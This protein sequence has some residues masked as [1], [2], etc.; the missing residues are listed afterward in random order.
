MGSWVGDLL[1]DDSATMRP[2]QDE[3]GNRCVQDQMDGVAKTSG[4]AEKQKKLSF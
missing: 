1:S 4:W 2:Q 3:A